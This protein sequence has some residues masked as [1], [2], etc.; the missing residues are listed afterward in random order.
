MIRPRAMFGLVVSGGMEWNGVG[1]SH[2]PLFGFVK[3][4]W[5]GMG[6]DGTHSIKYHSFTQFFIPPNLGCIQWNRTH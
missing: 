6:C 2:I 4:E 5:N 3:K 1:W